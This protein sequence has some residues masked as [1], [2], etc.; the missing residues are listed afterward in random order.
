MGNV[1][2]TR[3]PRGGP[4]NDLPGF[5]VNVLDGLYRLRSVT[6]PKG[7]VTSNFYDVESHLIAVQPPAGGVVST[8]YDRRGFVAGGSS[9]DGFWSQGVDG[10]GNVRRKTS[11][12]GYVTYADFDGIN[13]MIETRAPGTSAGPPMRTTWIHDGF[14]NGAHFTSETREGPDPRTTRTI[15]DHRQRPI[16]VIAS[17]GRSVVETVYNEQDQ[18]I[19]THALFD[20]I[21]QTAT[22]TFRDAR[23]RVERVR[24]QDA[25]YPQPA[26]RTSDTVALFNRVGSVVETID[27]MGR[28]S[29]NILDARERVQYVIDGKDVTVKEN[30]WGDDDL[31]MEVKA[32]DPATKSA[33]RVRSETRTYTSRKELKT[34]RNRNGMGLTY[35]YNALPGQVDTVTDSLGR[36]TKTTYD[37][38]TQRVDEVIVAQGS[39]SERRSKSVWQ[40]G[41]LL[42]SRVFNPATG[43]QDARY[44]HSYDQADR[45]ELFAA[46]QVAAERYS[47]TAFSEEA[48]VVMGRKSLT[49]GYN[50]LGQ[51]TTTTWSGAYNQLE[52]R[53]YNGLGQVESVANQTHEKV[54][55]YDTWLGTPAVEVFKVQGATWK[56]QTHGSDIAK[57]YTHLLDAENG[58][59][60][61]VHDQNNRVTAIKYGG[62]GVS[63]TVYTPGGLVD[64]TRI[65][66]A[67]GVVIAETLCSYDGIGRKVGQRTVSKAT[68]QVVAGFE[69]EYDDLDLVRAIK[70]NPLGVRADLRY[71]ERREL[72]EEVW[73]GNG[74]GETVPPYENRLGAPATGPESAPSNEAQGIPGGVLVVAAVTKRYGFDPAGNRVFTEINGVRTTYA[75][76]SAS[77]M[78]TETSPAETVSHEHDEW[79][80]ETARVTTALPAGGPSVTESYGFNYMNQ[81]SAY[82]KGATRWQYDFWPTG[83]RYAKVNLNDA[84]GNE[85]YVPRFGDVVTE[86]ST[87]TTHKNSYVQ[88]TGVDT[89]HT[90]ISAHGDR[91]HYLGDQVG[92]VSVTLTDGAVVADSSLKD[93]WGNPLA[94][95]SS[96]RYGFAQREHDSES[97]LIHMRARMYDS[98]TGRFTQTDP[99]LGNRP[100]K[101][102]LYGSNNPVS[103]VDPMGLEDNLWDWFKLLFEWETYTGTARYIKNNPEHVKAAFEEGVARPTMH[104]AEFAVGGAL[105]KTTKGVGIVTRNAIQGTVLATEETAYRGIV[106]GQAPTLKGF[107]TEAAIYSATGI[108][109]EGGVASAILLDKGAGKIATGVTDFRVL[110]KLEKITDKAV[111]FVDA[112]P[113]NL[114]S[115]LYL[116]ERD[117]VQR[118]IFVEANRGKA[119]ERMG[120]DLAR[121]DPFLEKHVDINP[122]NRGADVVRKGSDKWYDWTTSK[123]WEKHVD[124]YGDRGSHLNTDRR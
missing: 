23:D 111:D 24:V 91:R 62:R 97:A 100:S 95:S 75:Y 30:V 42:E 61:W 37:G 47:Y 52:R 94:G 34:M 40:N 93:V 13:R 49:H 108:L 36:V 90:R 21:L 65:V 10:N 89:K 5:T 120:R 122:P 96:E 72:I 17:D 119:I 80:N 84:A 81:M 116:G 113:G 117:Q 25:P 109:V 53:G 67:S 105:F 19:A 3:R 48:S 57:N 102:Y 101:H 43:Q 104:A 55:L 9:P 118:G 2:M 70:V 44:V 112:D 87:P 38:N 33:T 106:E 58:A 7:Q 60:E 29:K 86:Y 45:P 11:L 41:L 85:Y 92:T 15:Y 51:R 8:N 82:V 98:R 22:V 71:N 54:M 46:P 26:A 121:K 12:R 39:P 74:S 77:Q 88:G 124:K 64:V 69:W 103:R 79:G 31:L 115:L 78:V 56:I 99:I 66:D 35:A 76:N 32:P 4:G 27:P 83:E 28:K 59:H 50:L 107:A 1:T 73:S 16:R 6:D 20:G 18:V 63:E 114:K 14:A 123:A 68:G 110:R